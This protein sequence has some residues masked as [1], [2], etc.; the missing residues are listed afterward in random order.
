M[1]QTRESLLKCLISTFGNDHVRSLLPCQRQDPFGI[2]YFSPFPRHK[3]VEPSRRGAEG[4]QREETSWKRKLCAVSESTEATVCLHPTPASF[5][6]Q[7]GGQDEE[8][9]ASH[10]VRK[11][12]QS[13]SVMLIC[14]TATRSSC[15]LCVFIA[16]VKVTHITSTFYSIIFY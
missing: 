1:S 10:L 8:D 16:V 12:R 6:P 5:S 4:G 7:R 15:A 3:E 2:L 9:G 13:I 11:T 14:A